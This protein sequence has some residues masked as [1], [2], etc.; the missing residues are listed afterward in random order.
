[1]LEPALFLLLVF[2]FYA[3]AKKPGSIKRKIKQ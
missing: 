3:C 2:L 1:M